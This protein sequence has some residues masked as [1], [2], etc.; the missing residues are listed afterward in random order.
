MYLQTVVEQEL[1]SYSRPVLIYD[2][3]HI[4]K[5]FL[6]LIAAFDH[7]PTPILFAFKSFPAAPIISLA[8]ELGVGFEVSNTRE[9]QCLPQNLQGRTVSLN[10]PL[11]TCRTDFLTLGNQLQEQIEHVENSKPPLHCH[12]GLRLNHSLPINPKLLREPERRSRFGI[13]WDNFLDQAPLYRADIL[14]G[15][16]LHNGSEQNTPEFYRA[17]LNCLTKVAKQQQIPLRYINLG[18]G[19]HAI[20]EEQLT[21]LIGELHHISAEFPL[22]IEPGQVLCRNAGFLLCRV[23]SICFFGGGRYYINL[24]ASYDCHAKW[25]Y[26]TWKNTSQKAKKP[27]LLHGYISLCRWKTH[28]R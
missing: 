5:N 24:D 23:Q 16:H 13:D 28:L 7:N 22:F 9:Y 12:L 18:G 1:R 10:T 15:V 26:P 4:R 11:T 27:P 21:A 14:S 25:S 17:T 19:F 3:A 8:Y 2:I 20:P 6:A